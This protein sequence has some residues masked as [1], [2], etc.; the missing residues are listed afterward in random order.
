[1]YNELGCKYYNNKSYDKAK[2]YFY[3]AYN[4]TSDPIEEAIYKNNEGDALYCLKRYDDALSCY[5]VALDNQPNI[6][7]YKENAAST[8]NAL[9]NQYHNN[10]SYRTAIEYYDKANEIK[11]D[12]LYKENKADSYDS[13]GWECYNK[14]TKNGYTDAKYY[15]QKAYDISSDSSKYGKYR[16]NRDNAQAQLDKC[17]IFMVKIEYDNPILN[18]PEIIKTLT[19]NLSMNFFEVIDKVSTFDKDLVREVCL[20]GNVNLLQECFEINDEERTIQY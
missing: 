8:Y 11:P 20:S 2:D 5:K 4:N 19:S 10:K 7:E 12:S 18:Y 6:D 1:M 3:Q 9:G 16:Q 17:I 15:F 14:Q 13:L